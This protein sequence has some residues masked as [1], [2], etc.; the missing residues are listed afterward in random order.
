MILKLLSLIFSF[1]VLEQ[2]SLTNNIILINGEANLV[3]LDDQAFIVEVLRP[4]PYYFSSNLSHEEIVAGLIDQRNNDETFYANN[5]DRFVPKSEV[6]VLD[7]AEFIKFSTNKALLNRVAVSR[8]RQI[9]N[10]Y[11]DGGIQEIQLSII[12]KN[13][14]VSRLLTD[15]RLS[16]VQDLLIAFGVNQYAIKKRKEVRGGYDSNPFVRV[17]YK[18]R[19]R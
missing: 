10:D 17:A 18:K 6:N 1:F 15:N 9:A 7:N 11:I 5:E 8:I 16:S 4:V 12:D 2:S 3:V 19:V 13:S 14:T